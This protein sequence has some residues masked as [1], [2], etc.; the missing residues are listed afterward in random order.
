MDISKF[1][2][3][4]VYLRNSG[5]KSVKENSELAFR[6]PL[7]QRKHGSNDLETLKYPSVVYA[8]QT[9]IDGQFEQPMTLAVEN[10]NLDSIIP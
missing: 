8:L 9:I 2:D 10:T 1:S 4:R 6:R 5:I 3:G 7:W